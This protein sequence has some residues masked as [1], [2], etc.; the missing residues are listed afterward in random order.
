MYKNLNVV[1]LEPGPPGNGPGALT[2]KAYAL[3]TFG[4]SNII[5]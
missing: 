3:R 2:T 4:I 5:V 1:G